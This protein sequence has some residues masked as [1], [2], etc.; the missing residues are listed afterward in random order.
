MSVKNM[1]VLGVIAILFIALLVGWG[2]TVRAVGKL[3]QNKMV[4][5]AASILDLPAAKINGMSVSYADYIRDLQTLNKYYSSA[6][7]T[8]KPTDEQISDQVLSR[9]IANLLVASEA[10]KYGV[11]VADDD[12][13]MMKSKVLTQF[14]SEDAARAE[15]MNRYG[16]TLEDYTER[17]IK[18]LLVEQK[19]QAAFIAGDD[20]A[21][22]KYKKAEV[23]A[24]HI[25]F[26]VEDE[27]NDAKIKAQAEAVLKR[28]KNGED[29]AKLAGEF[30]SD[31]TKA[32]GGDL[33]WF[34]KG[35]MVPEFEEAVFAL[36]KDQLSDKLVKTQYGYHIIKVTDKR[37]AR[38]F[39]AFMDD[40][41]KN[42]KLK[43]YIPVHNP[44]EALVK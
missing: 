5:K 40:Q 41:I 1:F 38:D 12:I 35:D 8:E 37:D 19:L 33:G 39:A 25:L 30:G 42:G 43:L 11:K 27:K 15:L 20:E 36:E 6:D 13:N 21:G 14:E 28:I 32:S 44:F 22:N 10:K 3:S 18:P 2:L 17:V 16:W 4:L 34:G 24:S 31:S 23:K 26:M 7:S 29:F 9:L